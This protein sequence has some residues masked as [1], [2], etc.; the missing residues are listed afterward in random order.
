MKNAVIPF[1]TFITCDQKPLRG[2]QCNKTKDKKL[3]FCIT[4]V[5]VRVPGVG[6]SAAV[7]A[8]ACEQLISKK[9]LDETKRNA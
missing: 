3:V 6:V 2:T 9:T 5:G 1:T 4:R 7:A 8:V